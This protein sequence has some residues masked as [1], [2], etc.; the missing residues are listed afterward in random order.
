MVTAWI[1]DASRVSEVAA[2]H[3]HDGRCCLKFTEHVL[4]SALC[5]LVVFTEFPAPDVRSIT[6]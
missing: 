2:G 5:Q 4:H 6:Y 3:P 1:F